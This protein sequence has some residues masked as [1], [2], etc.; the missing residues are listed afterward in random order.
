MGQSGTPLAGFYDFRLVAVSLLICISASYAALDL[1]GRVTAAHGWSRAAW[2]VGGSTAMGLGIWSMHF[3]GMLA[4]HLP[5]PVTYYWPTVLL[6]LLAAMLGSALALHVV[7]REKMA[8]LQALGGSILMGSAIAGMHYMG[9]AAMRLPAE[10]HYNPLLVVASVIIA[11][12]ASFVS[13]GFCFDH[14]E[15]FRGTTPAK[16]LSAALMGVAISA[17]HYTGMA[18]ASFFSSGL[19]V[20]LAHTASISSLGTAAIAL[21]TLTVQ[22]VAILTSAM[23]RQLATQA[24]ELQRSERFRQI[25]DN[26]PL[27]LALATSDL[28]AF[29][30]V[31]HA[32][33]KIWGRTI[34]SLYANPMSFVDGIHP[35]DHGPFKEALSSLVKGFAIDGLECRVIHP[36]GSTYWVLCRG[37]A[38]RSASGQIAR[39]VGSAQDITERKEA[40][41]ELRRKQTYLVMGQRIA[42]LGTW[43]WKLSSREMVGSA[44]FSALVLKARN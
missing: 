33:E 35:D 19:P 42:G 21:A 23:D 25:A 38:V 22:G 44:A 27:V 4:F 28:S 12:V 7:S 32:Y 40:E 15:D 3:T 20:Q 6:S 1:G 29:L 36:D 16:L 13:L 30:Y 17:M 26:L 9:M 39:L 8:H 18:A 2:L 31:N 34:E 10:C 24:V 37:F 43:A 41:L 14:R 11:V 5:V